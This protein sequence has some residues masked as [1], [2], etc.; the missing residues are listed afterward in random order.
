MKQ[1]FINRRNFVKNGCSLPNEHFPI[2]PRI[3]IVISKSVCKNLFV[4]ACCCWYSRLSLR[5]MDQKFTLGGTIGHGDSHLEFLF[6]HHKVFRLHTIH[7]AAGTARTNS[8]KSPGYCYMIG[9]GP[10]SCLLGH[11]PR[12]LSCFYVKLFLPS[13][14]KF[15]EFWSSMSSI[16]PDI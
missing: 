13:I 8:G 14:F 6:R 15:V 4:S 16:V 3:E 2:V 5:E 7:D 9:R 10:N 1:L 11:V 12:L